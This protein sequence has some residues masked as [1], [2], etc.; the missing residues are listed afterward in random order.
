MYFLEN[1]P[2]EPW[3]ESVTDNIRLI[4][5]NDKVYLKLYFERSG[6]AGAY[7]FQNSGKL[8]KKTAKRERDEFMTQNL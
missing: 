3:P 5:K 1:W 2:G 7:R 8:L 6:E 4:Q